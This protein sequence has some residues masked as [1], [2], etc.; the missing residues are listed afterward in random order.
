MGTILAFNEP[1]THTQNKFNLLP[2]DLEMARKEQEL[3][4]RLADEEH[5]R[6]A[7]AA[8]AQNHDDK[9]LSSTPNGFTALN[10][11]R[12]S[13]LNASRDDVGHFYGGDEYAGDGKDSSAK[14][15]I[16]YAIEQA[17]I[18]NDRIIARITYRLQNIDNRLGECTRRQAEIDETVSAIEAD[19][20][21]LEAQKDVAEEEKEALEQDNEDAAQ[22]TAEAK[23]DGARY[24]RGDRTFAWNK[25]GDRVA[26][27][28]DAAGVGDDFRLVVGAERGLVKA[29]PEAVSAAKK[30][31]KDA[32]MTDDP[33]TAMQ[34]FF[35]EHISDAERRQFWTE[36]RLHDNATT[37][38]SLNQRLEQNQAK[39]DALKGESQAITEERERLTTERTALTEELEARNKY[40]EKISSPTYY[41]ELEALKTKNNYNWR[42]AANAYEQE[43]LGS[44]ANAN[45]CSAP[46]RSASGSGITADNISLQTDFSAA[47]SGVPVEEQAPLPTLTPERRP[48]AAPAAPAPA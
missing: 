46:R 40:K 9:D 12:F 22:A 25:Y 16:E 47:A 20:E 41:E 14:K 21:D 44:Y 13:A 43:C 42:D 2:T 29:D 38:E 11:T 10:K 19:N 32:G 23:S 30:R 3:L 36:K 45:T 31:I 48:A 34:S 28:Y 37:L 1:A 39:L 4:T 35:R 6:M 18:R 17:R 33:R 8:E 24:E 7:A 15:S 26:A 27:Q 5:A